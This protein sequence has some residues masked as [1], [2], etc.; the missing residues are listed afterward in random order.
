VLREL[1][2]PLTSQSASG[3]AVHA[4]TPFL[5]VQGRLLLLLL[6]LLVMV[7]SGGVE[8]A[9]FLELCRVDVTVVVVVAAATEDD[10]GASEE[11]DADLGVL[12]RND[13]LCAGVAGTG[14]CASSATSSPPSCSTVSTEAELF[15]LVPP[16]LPLDPPLCLFW[17]ALLFRRNRLGKRRV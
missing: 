8:R 9:R 15:R 3:S 12:P 6:L 17:P 13:S 4:G 16:L 11:D 2:E 1:L 7:F 5:R 14:D 10:V